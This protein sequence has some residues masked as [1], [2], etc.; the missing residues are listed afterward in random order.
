MSVA[1]IQDNKWE[2]DASKPPLK[3]P[4]SIGIMIMMTCFA[5][6]FLWVIAF[7]V[8]GSFTDAQEMEFD[9][10]QKGGEPAAAA[11]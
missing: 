11:E 2:V 9:K 10:K 1:E 4:A 7:A 3:S 6:F 5:L 8:V